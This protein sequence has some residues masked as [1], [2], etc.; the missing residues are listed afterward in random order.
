MVG[1]SN[2]LDDWVSSLLA[3]ME[4][5]GSMSYSDLLFEMHAC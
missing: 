3:D 4:V 1:Y 5:T 2:A